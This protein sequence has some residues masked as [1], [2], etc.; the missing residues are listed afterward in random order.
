MNWKSR[1]TVVATGA[2]LLT[3][4]GVA[5]VA[6]GMSSNDPAASVDDSALRPEDSSSSATPTPSPSVSPFF[7]D[8]GGNRPDGVSDDGPDHDLFDDNGGDRDDDDSDNDDDSDSDDDSD[9]DDDSSDRGSGS[10][11]D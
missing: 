1:T 2:V 8:N 5:A 9:H 4:L 3:G 11:D 7:D 10:D 6:S